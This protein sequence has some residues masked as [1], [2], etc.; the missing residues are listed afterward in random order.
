MDWS[1][2]FDIVV[3]MLTDIEVVV[4]NF[5][6]HISM[7]VVI[8]RARLVLS[9]LGIV[10]VV[11]NVDFEVSVTIVIVRNGVVLLTMMVVVLVVDA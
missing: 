5:R 3:R 11:V 4:T 6:L 1:L 9:I 2:L 7:I 8:V 10:V